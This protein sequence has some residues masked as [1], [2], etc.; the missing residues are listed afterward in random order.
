MAKGT[1]SN[2][3]FW[4]RFVD[5]NNFDYLWS[6]VGFTLDVHRAG[7]T[8][9]KN[10]SSAW[11][12]GSVPRTLTRVFDG[13]HAGNTLRINGTDQSMTNGS[14]SDPGTSAISAALSVFASFSG[15]SP[16]PGTLGEI[17][18]YSRALSAGEVQ[19][20]EGYFRGRYGHY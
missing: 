13:T 10:L 6:D 2:G 3:Y 8:S 19:T 1:A 5:V 11:G 17:V 16:E 15:T 18:V 7:L 9:Q 14:T 4:Y 20:L 12:N